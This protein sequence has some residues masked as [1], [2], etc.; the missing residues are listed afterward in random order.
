MLSILSSF[1]TDRLQRVTI[2]GVE[3]SWMPVLAG[4]SQGS[5]L[6]PL[7]FLVYI[8]DLLNGIESNARIFADD[9]SLFHVSSTR[10]LLISS[11]MT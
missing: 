7:L 5:I 10:N 8:N 3:S 9:A 1:L 11:T 6:G 2:E 4:V